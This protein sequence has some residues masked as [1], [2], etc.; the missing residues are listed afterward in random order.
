MNFASLIFRFHSHSRVSNYFPAKVKFYMNLR[1]CLLTVTIFT[2]LRRKKSVKLINV[3]RNLLSPTI[4]IL[5]YNANSVSSVRPRPFKTRT[6]LFG[7]SDNIINIIQNN[8][9]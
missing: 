4:I 7:Y 5:Y 6:K 9:C 8:R 1:I 3:Y 2:F